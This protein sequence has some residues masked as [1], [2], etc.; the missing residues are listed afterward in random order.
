MTTAESLVSLKGVWCAYP[1]GVEA[2]RGVDLL[3]H[4]G[5]LVALMGENGSGKTTLARLLLGLVR[6]TE[7]SVRV[8][9]LDAALATTSQLAR[10]VGLVFQNPDHQIFEKS[11]RDEVA[12]GPK[13]FRL[14]PVE[15]RRR[16]EE[17]LEA[18]DLQ[19]QAD[20][21][22]TSLSVG[23]RKAV[24][25][26]STFVLNPKVILLDEPTRGMDHGRKQRLASLGRRLQ[27]AGRTLVYLTHDVEFAYAATD[28]AVVLHRGR[29]LL[30]GDTHSVLSDPAILEAGLQMAT[31]PQLA[32]MLGPLGVPPDVAS[33]EGIV[34]HFSGGN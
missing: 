11:V 1:N 26:A 14:S 29:V 3:L 7:G 4:P 28:R 32:A 23:E 13:N 31:I 17:Q 19:S 8:L 33:L 15:T 30:D 27:S 21:L 25:L 18:F 24:A 34:R 10:H 9:N 12:F 20:R 5:E 22:P 6:P 16:V 2:L